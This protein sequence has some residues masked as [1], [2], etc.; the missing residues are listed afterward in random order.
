[1]A[2][3]TCTEGKVGGLGNQ[4]VFFVASFPGD[5][6]TRGNENTPQGHVQSPQQL[7]QPRGGHINTPPVTLQVDCPPGLILRVGDAVTYTITNQAGEIVFQ[8][9]IFVSS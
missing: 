1:T 8:D 6:V 4:P 9:V 5:C 7:I 3:V 2:T